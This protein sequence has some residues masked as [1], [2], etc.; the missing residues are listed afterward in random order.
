MSQLEDV[1][2]LDT[3][4]SLIKRYSRTGNAF[5]SLN[6]ARGIDLYSRLP[7]DRLKRWLIK[8]FQKNPRAILGLTRSHLLIHTIKI[9]KKN[10]LTALVVPASVFAMFLA[11]LPGVVLWGTLIS[12]LAY[13]F[14]TSVWISIKKLKHRKEI[15]L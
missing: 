10:G 1:R 12:L 3:A 2:H 15:Q 8:A 6:G 4:S 13:L 7:N 11:T 9:F 14:I 5:I